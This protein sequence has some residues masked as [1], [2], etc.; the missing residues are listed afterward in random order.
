MDYHEPL[1]RCRCFDRPPYICPQCGRRSKFCLRHDA[2]YCP[3]CDVWLEPVCGS[4]RCEFCN[5]R[6]QRPSQAITE[7]DQ[8]REGHD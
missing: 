5:G 6:P 8:R 3:L 4:K 1:L 2:Y 7:L